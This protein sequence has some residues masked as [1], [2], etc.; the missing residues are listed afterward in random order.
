MCQ[1]S[2]GEIKFVTVS[3]KAFAVSSVGLEFRLQAAWE[4]VRAT[5][6]A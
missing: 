2:S 4:K 1:V 3:R 6:T 5:K